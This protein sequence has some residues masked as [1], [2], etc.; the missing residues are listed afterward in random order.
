MQ[1]SKT[2]KDRYYSSCVPWFTDYHGYLEYQ[3][4]DYHS[5]LDKLSWSLLWFC[6]ENLWKISWNDRIKESLI[7]RILSSFSFVEDYWKQ[8]HKIMLRNDLL[9]CN[10]KHS[11]FY[12]HL[13]FLPLLAFL[14]PLA[15][16][17]YSHFTSPAFHYL[18]FYCFFW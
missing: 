8:F 17:L 12:T 18:L 9:A 2:S 1:S 4:L 11:L 16:Y 10:N 14:Q 3:Y 15:F 7:T 13:L 6:W 5:F